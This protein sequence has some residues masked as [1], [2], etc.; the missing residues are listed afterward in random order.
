M[1]VDAGTIALA[2]A[3]VSLA[4]A[5]TGLIRTI[6]EK[7]STSGTTNVLPK[8]RKFVPRGMANLLKKKGNRL[9]T[10]SLAL[11]TMIK[12]LMDVDIV[13][14]C[15]DDDHINPSNMNRILGS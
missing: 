11:S 8:K 1:H 7:Q 13:F 3:I 6:L 9:T 14:T 2:T 5:M 15:I 4:T 10:G 12:P